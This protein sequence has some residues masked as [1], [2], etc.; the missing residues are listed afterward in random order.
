MAEL[1]R[2]VLTRRSILDLERVPR[3]GRSHVAPRPAPRY[4]TSDIARGR[5]ERTPNPRIERGM[6]LGFQIYGH[7]GEANASL[8]R[9]MPDVPGAPYGVIRPF[10]LERVSCSSYPFGGCS[11]CDTVRRLSETYVS[12]ETAYGDRGVRAPKR[13][14]NRGRVLNA[15]WRR[16]PP[17]THAR[18][19]ASFGDIYPRFPWGASG[20]SRPVGP[21]SC[22]MWTMSGSFGSRDPRWALLD[23]NGRYGC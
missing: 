5:P 11:K 8:G 1:T 12:L 18:S 9:V 2:S 4:P 19:F 13:R 16:A 17:L 3:S 21:I 15:P 7:G 20:R 23:W 10:S 14:F 6:A 22:S